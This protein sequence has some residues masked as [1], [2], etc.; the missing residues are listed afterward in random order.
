MPN[1]TIAAQS[2][3]RDRAGIADAQPPGPRHLSPFE[4]VNLQFERAADL[5]GLPEELRLALKT[6]YREVMVELPLRCQDGSLRTFSGYRVQHDHSRGPMK[7][8][9]RYHPDV[10]LEETRALA[11]LM[12]WKTAVV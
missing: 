5:I 2:A 7:G 10:D 1:P 3:D 8:G 4:A 11:S 12:T 9:I 6:P